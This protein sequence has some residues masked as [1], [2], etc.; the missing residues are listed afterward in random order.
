MKNKIC[1]FIIC[2]VVFPLQ[3]A[4]GQD[5]ISITKKIIIDDQS[6]STESTALMQIQIFNPYYED[7]QVRISDSTLFG[8]SGIAIACDELM[9]LSQT[10]LT[11]DYPIIAINQGDYLIP[12]AKLSYQDPDSTNMIEVF[13][14]EINITISDQSP[15]DSEIL[16]IYNCFGQDF[17]QLLSEEEIS[18]MQNSSLSNQAQPDTKSGPQQVNPEQSQGPMIQ[19]SPPLSQSPST[20][21]TAPLQ[22]GQVNS[23]PSS[24]P[25]ELSPEERERRIEQTISTI[26]NYFAA[27]SQYQG[28]VNNP[29]LDINAEMLEEIQKERQ[30]RNKILEILENDERFQEINGK[31][32]EEGY[33][34]GEPTVN[35]FPENR[36]EASITYQRDVETVTVEAQ[37]EGE[38]L[39]RIE[40]DFMQSEKTEEPYFLLLLLGVIPAL[41]LVLRQ[42]KQKPVEQLVE[43]TNTKTSQIVVNS[44]LIEKS[45]ELFDE[46]PKEAVSLL[47][48]LI[49]QNLAEKYQIKQN[50]TNNELI[51]FLKNKKLDE[52]Q[53]IENIF[54]ICDNVE[55]ARG[56]ITKTA[57]YNLVDNVSRLLNK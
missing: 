39:V 23:P 50:M 34:P 19:F 4:Y 42:R 29:T 25:E 41:Y 12:P 15:D 7:L 52:Y 13:S 35:L 22:Q 49:R 44:D 10:I 14:N 31:I 47:A 18:N 45:K 51:D 46:R 28:L 27:S 43:N 24:E 57:F 40:S 38:Q 53:L 9:A 1:V 54:R 2:L 36:A 55:F 5:Q 20:Q 3:G 6:N 30:E 48:N 56:K 26:R 33:F 32:L 8:N 21:S 37:F 11:V 16:L 17:R